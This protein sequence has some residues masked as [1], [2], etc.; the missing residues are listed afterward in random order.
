VIEEFFVFIIE[1]IQRSL[2]VEDFFFQKR[3][4]FLSGK[5]K[6]TGKR[7]LFMNREFKVKLQVA[8]TEIAF[9]D[10]GRFLRLLFFLAVNLRLQFIDSILLKL[11]PKLLV[12]P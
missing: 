10:C 6:T 9:C 7:I 12:S 1:F 4:N 5:E 8:T 11:T 3:R 2:E